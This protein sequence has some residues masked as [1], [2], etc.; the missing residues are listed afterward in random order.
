MCFYVELKKTEMWGIVISKLSC[1]TV[2]G[3]EIN[4]LGNFGIVD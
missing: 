1:V 4:T 3:D 2:N